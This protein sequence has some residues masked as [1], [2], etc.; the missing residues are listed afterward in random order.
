MARSTDGGE[1]F[2]NFK[3]NDKPF[4]PN[5]GIFFG[6]YNNIVARGDLVRPIWTRLDEMELSVKTALVDVAAIPSSSPSVETTSIADSSLNDPNVLYTSFKLP[7]A[8]KVSWSIY[9]RWGQKVTTI[10]K[11]KALEAGKHIH[12]VKFSELDLIRGEQ[13]YHRV[14]H[15]KTVYQERSFIMK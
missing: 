12:S 8:Q 7:K 6:D 1:T 4:S 9:N 3:I 11:C 13:Y 14:W 2:V 15:K 10:F 5:E